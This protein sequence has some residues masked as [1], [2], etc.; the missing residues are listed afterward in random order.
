[1]CAAA[2]LPYFCLR[3]RSCI[4][5]VLSTSRLIPVGQV[6]NCYTYCFMYKQKNVVLESIPFREGRPVGMNAKQEWDH[7]LVSLCSLP[8]Q[9]QLG[10]NGVDSL[11]P[12][13]FCPGI[14]HLDYAL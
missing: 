1:M 2:L 9:G 5:L 7:S 14:L 3:Q 12:R 11:N 6:F 10:F 13:C 4:S 8:S